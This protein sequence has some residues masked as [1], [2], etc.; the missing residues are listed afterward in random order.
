MIRV[1]RRKYLSGRD[2]ISFALWSLAITVSL[3]VLS[4]PVTGQTNSQADYNLMIT[5]KGEGIFAHYLNNISIFT[6]NPGTGEVGE[7]PIAIVEGPVDP[8]KFKLDPGHYKAFFGTKC[9]EKLIGFNTFEIKTDTEKLIVF[10]SLVNP[11]ISKFSDAFY[12]FTS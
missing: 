9:I 12:C 8:V 7:E 3:V 10:Q 6:F 11:N 1:K 4:L 5:D 2:L